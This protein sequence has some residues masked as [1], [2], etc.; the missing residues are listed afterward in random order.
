M[1]HRAGSRQWKPSK[2]DRFAIGRNCCPFP[3]CILAPEG[4]YLNQVGLDREIICLFHSDLRNM[5][6]IKPLFAKD[7]RRVWGE[8][9][10]QQKSVHATR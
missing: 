3:K 5:N 9:L 6:S 4:H 7:R 1:K 8:P 10:V 2:A